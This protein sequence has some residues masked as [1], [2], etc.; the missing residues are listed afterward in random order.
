M[1]YRVKADFVPLETIT[2]NYLTCTTVIYFNCFTTKK[3][4]WRVEAYRISPQFAQ[5][6]D[7]LYY[8][9]PVPTHSMVLGLLDGHTAS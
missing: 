4:L 9:T 2:K 6:E 8:A 1:L 5:R 3:I 7:E